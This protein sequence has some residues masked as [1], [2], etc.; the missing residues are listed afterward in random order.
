MGGRQGHHGDFSL[1]RCKIVLS[2]QPGN[3]GVGATDVVRLLADPAD[4]LQRFFIAKPIRADD[5][6]DTV[7]VASE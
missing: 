3:G 4:G 2:G 7:A 1:R 5:P 6:G